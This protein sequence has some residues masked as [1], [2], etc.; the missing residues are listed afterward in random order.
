MSEGVS[1]GEKLV[2]ETLPRA[3]GR[4]RTEPAAPVPIPDPETFAARITVA[5]AEYGDRPTLVK[6]NAAATTTDAALLS[7]SIVL[8]VLLPPR[9][10]LG[11]K[12]HADIFLRPRRFE[13]RG[14][15]AEA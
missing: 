7:E 4:P 12:T 8:S 2:R 9:N 11:P 1:V 13:D 3:R 15:T 6:A 5:A 10:G 14:P